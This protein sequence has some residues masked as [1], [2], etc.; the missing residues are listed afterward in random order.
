MMNLK[1]SLKKLS[2]LISK[3]A[4][5]IFAVFAL[6]GFLDASYLTANHYLGASLVCP[7]F[8]DCEKVTA[9]QY[10]AIGGIPVALFGAVY[11]IFIFLL[12][13]WYLDSKK[14]SILYFIARATAVGFLAS[15]WFLYLQL[16]V[17][18]ALCLYCIISAITSTLLFIA[19]LIVLKSREKDF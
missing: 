6:I 17:I 7:I 3:H 18:L 19:G 9:S 5:W 8:G 1:L 15:V 12:V 10:S 14:E 4:G 11:Y 13:I 2:A 16:F